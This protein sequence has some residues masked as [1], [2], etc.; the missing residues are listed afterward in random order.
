M[1][2]WFD[3]PSEVKRIIY[4]YVCDTDS[5]KYIP[6]DR[7][8]TF[9][10]AYHHAHHFH[11]LLL[12]S[13]NFITADGFACAVLSK[14]KLTFKRYNELRRC[15]TE[16][17]SAV[18]A[19]VRHMHLKIE[20][21]NITPYCPDHSD[22]FTSFSNIEGTLSQS[23]PDLK[24][25]YLSIPEYCVEIAHHRPYRNQGPTPDEYNDYIRYIFEG[26]PFE[27]QNG[28]WVKKKRLDNIAAAFIGDRNS[29]NK[30]YRWRRVTPW[31]RRLILYAEQ[32]DIEIVLN[33]M[34]CITNRTSRLRNWG[35][36]SDLQLTLNG[37][38]ESVFDYCYSNRRARDFYHDSRAPYLKLHMPATMS[39]KDYLLKVQHGVHSYSVY[40][41]L[42]FAMIHA[43]GRTISQRAW[44]ELLKRFE[45]STADVAF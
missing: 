40:Q 22:S 1:T 38:G 30:H 23:F 33:I 17:N 7:R 4:S 18:R 32:K 20:W 3:L 34:L 11:D 9:D 42:A 45:L 31:L 27:N 29:A 13:K 8:R 16:L 36:S 37:V 14:A 2:D 15:A 35:T 28:L 12:V 21:T 39:T 26:T 43:E 10:V 24:K 5:V 44:E 19:G 41:G 6:P 25:I